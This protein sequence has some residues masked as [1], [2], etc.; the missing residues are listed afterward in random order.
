MERYL[1]RRINIHEIVQIIVIALWDNM[2]NTHHIL[3]NS[4][5]YVHLFTGKFILD[6]FLLYLILNSN[7]CKIC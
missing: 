3:N 5:T 2:Y 4:L 6:M 7:I 1:F